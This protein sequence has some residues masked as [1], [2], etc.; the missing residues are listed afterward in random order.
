MWLAK[1]EAGAVMTKRQRPYKPSTV[2][3]YREGMRLRVLPVLGAG[4][5]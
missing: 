3:G 4:R 2:R 1:A 5:D